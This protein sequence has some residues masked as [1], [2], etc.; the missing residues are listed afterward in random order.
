MSVVK[1]RSLQGDRMPDALLLSCIA[2]GET[3]A[4]G[5]LYD[6][7]APALLRFARRLD[8]QEAEDIVQTVFMRVLHLAPKFDV[9]VAS[10]RPWLYAITAKVAMEQHRSFL[11]WKTT[12]TCLARQSMSDAEN[13]SELQS[14]LRTS[15]SR[16]SAD[17]R[18]VL[19]LA[20]VEGFSGE[21]IA[22][23]LGIPVGT[24]WTRLHYAR[25]QL[26]S[27]QEDES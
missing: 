3:E 26:R 15:L 10:A 19:V 23:M 9:Q 18:T 20:E 24:V 7:Y 21:E 1:R 8:R 13:P 14:D 6:R 27:L 12:R 25:R 17:K 22:Q 16:L 5:I 4:L 11:R 2:R